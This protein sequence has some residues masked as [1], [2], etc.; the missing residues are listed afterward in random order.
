MGFPHT[1]FLSDTKDL[2]L[3]YNHGAKS[4][5]GFPFALLRLIAS[6]TLRLIA[7]L[8]ALRWAGIRLLLRE[9]ALM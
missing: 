9:Y 6:Y 7:P 4:R 8:L 3:N 1:P 2:R 5:R